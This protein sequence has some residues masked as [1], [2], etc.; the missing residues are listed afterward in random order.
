MGSECL[1]IV[2]VIPIDATFQFY[3]Q[4]RGC[5][6]RGMWVLVRVGYMTLHTSL[7]IYSSSLHHY[8]IFFSL[9]A[10]SMPLYIYLD[11]LRHSIDV[12]TSLVSIL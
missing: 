11:N 2:N 8:S 4:V 3:G 5:K 1:Q 12:V 6:L 7:G 10:K 9:M